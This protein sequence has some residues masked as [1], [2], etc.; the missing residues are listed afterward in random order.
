MRIQRRFESGIITAVMKPE[1]AVAWNQRLRQ[2]YLANR[3]TL[4]DLV[5]W[6]D[7]AERTAQAIPLS[8]FA[9]LMKGKSDG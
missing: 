8:G 2:Y 5:D 7:W 3:H 6:D 1:W 9:D 4:K